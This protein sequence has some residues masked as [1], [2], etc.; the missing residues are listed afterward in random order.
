[1]PQH[2][3]YYISAKLTL[4]SKAVEVDAKV[5]E[6]HLLFGIAQAKSVLRAH[7]LIRS[8]QNRLEGGISLGYC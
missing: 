7:M 1:M 4:N 8:A 5:A 2:F 3:R 6:I